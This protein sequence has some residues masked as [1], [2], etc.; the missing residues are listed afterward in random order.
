MSL[1]LCV[2]K[3]NYLSVSQ[4]PIQHARLLLALASFDK[5]WKFTDSFNM[6][7]LFP[8]FSCKLIK[9][10]RARNYIVMVTLNQRLVVSNI[11]LLKMSLWSN[12]IPRVL[13]YPPYGARER[14]TRENAG[15]VSPEQNYFWGRSPLSHIFCLVY[16]ATFTQWS[17]QQDRFTN[18]TSTITETKGSFC[19]NKTIGQ[20]SELPEKESKT[21]V[22]AVLTDDTNR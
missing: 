16:F 1:N 6:T 7:N 8:V 17:Q 4:S 14:E 10:L 3:S 5:L 22:V 13:S 12:L 19:L 15:H 18:P 21:S 20:T 2:I 11:W 9:P